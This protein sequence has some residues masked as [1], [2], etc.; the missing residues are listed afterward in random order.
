MQPLRKKGLITQHL[1]IQNITLM[2]QH[3]PQKFASL[4]RLFVV[5]A[6]LVAG[7]NCVL[8]QYTEANLV[9]DG[10]TKVTTLEALQVAANS[11]NKFILLDTRNTQQAM[12]WKSNSSPIYKTLVD[13]QSNAYQTWL[14]VNR[15]NGYFQLRSIADQTKC[16]YTESGS[17]DMLFRID[18]TTT[19][20]NY[21]FAVSDGSWMIQ[22][23]VDNLYVGQ[24]SAKDDALN[25]FEDEERIWL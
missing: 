23:S 1:I 6:I 21:L 12:S 16:A 13:P 20:S 15:G 8:A 19:A 3:F 11:G 10:W 4:K 5:L 7:T 9:S 24:W 25:T 22:N 14:L 2:K 18:N 17:W